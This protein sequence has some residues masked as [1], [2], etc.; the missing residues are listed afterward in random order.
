M[1]HKTRE[2]R[3]AALLVVAGIAV[4]GC[5]ATA[6]ST[7]TAADIEEAIEISE[8]RR[9]S[10]ERPNAT[11]DGVRVQ[12]N[13]CEITD[14][15]LVDDGIR[16]RIWVSAENPRAENISAIVDIT[17]TDG[18]VLQ[19]RSFDIGAAAEGEPGINS[20]GTFDIVESAES[21][22]GDDCFDEIKAVAVASIGAAE[23][24]DDIDS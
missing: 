20:L 24:M 9:P 8:E 18:T 21:R 16:R 17:M 11:L 3:W 22:L 5:G 23:W 10:N 2:S 15:E 19:S 14:A 1:H 4:T 7:I 6:S 12:A 13:L